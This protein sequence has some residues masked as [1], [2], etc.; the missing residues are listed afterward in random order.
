MSSLDGI[1]VS[2][3]IMQLCYGYLWVAL[4]S[5]RL[6]LILLS[7]KENGFYENSY[8]LGGNGPPAPPTKST[9][10]GTY[11]KFVLFTIQFE[12]HKAGKCTVE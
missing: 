2:Q 1:V 3:T 6:K 7:I 10:G 5:K 12:L 8:T 4:G 11:S 9:P